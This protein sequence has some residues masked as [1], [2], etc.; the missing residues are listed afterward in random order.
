MTM[1]V[2]VFVYIYIYIEITFSFIVIYEK[3]YSDVYV[4]SS[5][6]YMA[7]DCYVL[8]SLFFSLACLLA[9]RLTYQL[10]FSQIVNMYSSEDGGAD[11]P[12]RRWS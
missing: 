2:S 5:F 4:F 9:F 3:N 7:L 6:S 10:D 8:F 12:D 11:T 1:S